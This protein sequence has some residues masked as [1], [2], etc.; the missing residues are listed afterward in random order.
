M[1]KTIFALLLAAC[2]TSKQQEAAS[3]PSAQDYAPYQLGAS[4]TYAIN[5]LGQKGQQTITVVKEEE[6]YFVDDQQGRFRHTD[7]GLRDA[8]R[9][10]IR[11]PLEE[12]NE[13]KAILS[14]SSVEHY[15]II[16]VGQPCEA[17]AGR[18]E[19]CLV[20]ESKNR[21]DEKTTLLATFTWARGIGLVK[22]ETEAEIKGKG[23][24]PQT[25]RSLI[26]YSLNPQPAS[27]DGPDTW[28]K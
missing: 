1:R 27:D 10:L 22:I 16:G 7:E 15:R 4:W 6:G 8:T 13:W 23:R 18:F 12:G 5:Y 19:D 20:I 2:A 26:H 3:G 11:N 9:F 17:Q 25:E 14:A 28:S 21:R 24:V